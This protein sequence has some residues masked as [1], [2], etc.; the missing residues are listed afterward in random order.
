VQN[1]HEDY[2]VKFCSAL[3]GLERLLGVLNGYRK[4]TLELEEEHEAL[5]EVLD[6]IC[7]LLLVT[8]CSDLFKR[9]QGFEL[10]MS[11]CRKQAKLRPH[12]IKVFDFAITNNRKNNKYLIEQG[13]L[14][15]IF[16][17]F[18]QKPEKRVK[19]SKID[20]TLYIK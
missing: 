12:I 4:K 19:K 5:V 3:N 15:V 7:A 14:P 17:F 18:M 10:L 6:A 16:G 20:S 9:L 11:V 8:E 2:K 13:G 1:S